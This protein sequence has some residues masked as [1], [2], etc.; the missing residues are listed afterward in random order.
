TGTCLRENR[1]V[2]VDCAVYKDGVRQ[3]GSLALQDAYEAGRDSDAFVWIGLHEPSA[4]EFESVRREF[5]LHELAVEDALKAH[6]RPK[7]E[8][9]DHTLFMVLKT[10][11]YAGADEI[12]FGEILL[13]VGDGFIISVRHGEMTSL[14][15]VRRQYESR[16]DLLRHGPGAILHA[17]VDRVIDDYAPVISDIETDIDEVEAQVFSRKVNPSERIY[18]LLSEVLDLHRAVAPLVVPLD[19]LASGRLPQIPDD[20]KTY[21]RDVHDHV[22]R[23]VEQIQNFRDLLSS[24]LAANLT[25]VSVRQNEDMRKISAVAAL[26]AVPTMVAGFYGMNFHY[27]PELDWKFGYPLVMAVMAIIEMC[28]FRFFRRRGWI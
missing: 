10:A 27:M 4:D 9:Y 19:R 17:I 5:D 21:F 12:E 8:I 28:L 13:F 15:G 23:T 1:Y 24:V 2:I 20:V 3:A 11:K 26:F 14:G 7:L 6:Q 22:L 25:E 16:P 18:K